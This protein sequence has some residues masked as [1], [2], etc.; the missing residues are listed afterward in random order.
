MTTITPE[1]VASRLGRR[2]GHRL[3]TYR[4]VG[5]PFWDVPLRCRLL[6]R[7]PLPALDEFT[8]RCV[9][10]GLK[11]SAEVQGFL[12]LPSRV[13]DTVMGSLVTSGHLSPLLDPNTGGAAYALTERGKTAVLELSAIV[14]EERTLSLGYDGLLRRYI[15]IERSLR[16]RPR[17]LRGN[18]IL[19]IPSF[20]ADPPNV[21]PADTTMV[22]AVIREA[23]EQA[24]QELVAVL[25]VDGKREKF[26]VKAVALVFQSIDRADEITIQ[27]AVDGRLS[28]EHS[29]AF[30]KA[31][32]HRKLGIVGTLQSAP[33]VAGQLLGPE[34]L[35]QLA[36]DAEVAAL[37]NAT[38]GF[39]ER[40]TDLRERATESEGPGSDHLAAEAELVA[41]RIDQ[42]EAALGQLPVRLLEVHEHPA[43][44]EEAL[45]TAEERLLI[46]SPWIRAAVVNEAFVES[47]RV[48]LS[49][50]VEVSIAYGID[51]GKLVFD[52]DSRAQKRLEDLAAQH[53]NFRFV[54]LGDTHAKV[55]LVDQRFVVVTS[56]N[57]LSFRGDPNRPFRDERG[58][59]VSLTEQID[60]I[61]TDYLDRMS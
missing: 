58:T 42:A 6:A 22:A 34:I 23:T 2:P 20:P 5:L 13:V 40:L 53:T 48:L 9:D 21:S 4:E 46:V 47:L 7:K 37:R 35:G 44:L 52:R 16:W 41:Q 25:G 27:F 38:E 10:A 54:R 31:E 45:A 19:E 3:L 1:H 15:D 26:F 28:E 55:L 56:Y 49:R 60:R 30:A 51:D 50:G 8:L 11:V 43:L 33:S 32:G 17:D 29:H 24:H 61:Y 57:W 39:R 14:P 36:D 59:L 18:D 12:G